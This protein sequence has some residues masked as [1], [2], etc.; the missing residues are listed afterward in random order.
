MENLHLQT[1]GFRNLLKQ[2]C[3]VFMQQFGLALFAMSILMPV[4]LLLGYLYPHYAAVLLSGAPLLSISLTE[5]WSLVFFFLSVPSIL[6]F[7]LV[8]AA[9]MVQRDP[10]DDEEG[11]GLDKLLGTVGKP[12]F[13]LLPRML[14]FLFASLVHLVVGRPNPRPCPRL[15]GPP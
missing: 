13:E 5:Y 1:Q 8:V 10:M 3:Q 2:S 15:L 14:G 7:L 11:L 9:C 12:F 4:I 6:V